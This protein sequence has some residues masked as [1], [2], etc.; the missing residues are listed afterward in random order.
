MN[1]KAHIDPLVR[2]II[3]FD[4]MCNSCDAAVNFIIDHD[5]GA[6]FTFAPL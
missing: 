2:P 5:P 4:G 3:L 6:R 1:A